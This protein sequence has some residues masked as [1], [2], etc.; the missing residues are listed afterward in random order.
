MKSMR[1]AFVAAVLAFAVLFQAGPR[2][3]WADGP[4]S[5]RAYHVV[6]SVPLPGEGAGD[7][8]VLD[9]KTRRLYV[10]HGGMVQVLDADSLK[11]IGTVAGTPHCH[12]VVL[13]DGL[14]KGFVSSGKP[15][16]VVVFDLKTL[17]HIAEIPS[18]PDTDNILYDH[19]SGRMFT[20]NGDSH[21]STVFDPSTF[22]VLKVLD[23][24]G[25]PEAPV[26]DGH[27]KIYD[28]LEDKNEVI[29]I[30]TGS[31]L[32]DKRWPVAPGK[33]P[34]GMAMD[35]KRHRLFIGC[36]NKLLVVMDSTNGRIIQTLP[37]G[38]HT[39]TTVFDPAGR[40]IYD[41]CGDGT[42][43]VVHEDSEDKYHVV[44][45][46]VTEAGA[47][48]MAFDPQTGRVF[49]STVRFEGPPA[50]TQADPKPHRRVVQDSF[51]ILV[52]ER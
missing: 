45:N 41:S 8:V 1:G 15:G 49:L 25:G 46:A 19:E 14:G 23:L 51:H 5:G 22:K 6:Q 21:S 33:S 39:D 3:V 47:K 18:K 27:G 30:D 28:D 16:S 36:R 42:L 29:R 11:L 50:A 13:M 2:P 52:A 34:S 20:F 43:S 26:D 12:G 4:G 37:I 9:G 32:I 17:K 40:N 38:G 31:L 35:R 48:T 7:Y 24:G 44:E 10:T